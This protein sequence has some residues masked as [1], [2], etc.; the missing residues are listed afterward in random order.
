MSYKHTWHL[1]TTEHNQETWNSFVNDTEKLYKKL[2]KSIKLTGCVGG[3]TPIFSEAEICFNGYGDEAYETFYLK[4]KELNGYNFCK[5]ERKPYDFM[6]QV[7][8]SLYK[9]YFS[10]VVKISSDGDQSDW[11][12]ALTFIGE[13][14]GELECNIERG[15]KCL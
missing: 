1:S 11:D 6:V 15:F 5:T 8:L 7:T 13:N 14:I 2:P 4:V 3:P 9:F 10:D 12:D